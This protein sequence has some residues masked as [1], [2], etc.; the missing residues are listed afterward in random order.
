M[1]HWLLRHEIQVPTGGDV[2]SSDLRHEVSLISGADQP[3][4]LEAFE[5]STSRRLAAPAFGRD[6]SDTER[7]SAVIVSVMLSNEVQKDAHIDRLQDPKRLAVVDGMGEHDEGRMM[8]HRRASTSSQ[9]VPGS[10]G[11]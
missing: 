1:I 3:G 7:D 2:G 4:L 6:R 8:L 10:G 5:R 9:S 11:I